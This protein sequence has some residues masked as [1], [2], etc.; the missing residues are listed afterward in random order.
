MNRLETS[1]ITSEIKQCTVTTYVPP[2]GRPSVRGDQS[3]VNE[4]DAYGFRP[5]QHPWQFLPAYEF[6]QQ[7]RCE[8]LLV[9]T[10]YQDRNL[11]PRTKWTKKGA[12]LVKSQPYKDGAVAARPGE[13]YVAVK[14]STDDYHLFPEDAGSFAHA[15]ASVRKRRPDVVVIEGLGLPSV[16]KTSVY[17]AQ[18]CSL[19]FRPWTFYLI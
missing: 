17:N 15:W 6:L 3:R 8:P 19:F 11:S 2:A 4:V 16:N 5:L 13:H 18:Y 10:H 14:S 1:H 7:W 9:P 12:E